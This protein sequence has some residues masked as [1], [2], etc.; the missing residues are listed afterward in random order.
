MDAF[1]PIALKNEAATAALARWLAPH[2][3]A[4][5]IIALAGSDDAIAA[6]RRVFG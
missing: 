6:A 1:P 4:G 5:D 3:K 2:L